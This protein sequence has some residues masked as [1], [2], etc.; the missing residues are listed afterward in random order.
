MGADNGEPTSGLHSREIG[1][2]NEKRLCRHKILVSWKL[3]VD[4]KGMELQRKKDFDR[5]RQVRWECFDRRRA[6]S[7][8][9]HVV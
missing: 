3:I 9:I 5:T 4:L 1:C 7:L 8:L 6:L 2:F